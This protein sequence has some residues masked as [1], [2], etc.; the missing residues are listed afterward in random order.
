[1][2]EFVCNYAPV[3]FLPYRETGE[4]VNVGVAVFCPEID[5]FDF[6]LELRKTKRVHGFF[7]EIEIPILRDSI[8]TLELELA[9]KRT[10]SELQIYGERLDPEQAAPRTSWFKDLIRPREALLHFGEPGVM[11]VDDPR[12]ALKQLFGDLVRR[13]FA[14]PKEYQEIK[15]RRRLGE[16][17]REWK[18]PYEK[19]KPIGDNEYHVTMPF[20]H[21][22]NNTP[23]KA[24]KPFDLDKQETSEIYNHGDTWL[25]K[26]RRLAERKHLPREVVFTVK[27]PGNRQR[28]KAANAICGE[29]KD[30]KVRIVEFNHTDELRHAVHVDELLA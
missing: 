21:T 20:V 2:K 14:L 17:L 7:P 24:I 30:M 9:R 10:A 26:L 18:F 15:M 12:E 13:Q 4:F 8:Y 6:R 25:A 16:L 28:R 19:D 27:M 22:L 1:M 3:R 23:V 11:L 5:W 29:L